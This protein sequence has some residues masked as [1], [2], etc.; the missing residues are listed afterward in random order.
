MRQIIIN[1][2]K[3]NTTEKVEKQFENDS[4]GY[5]RITVDRPRRETFQ[6]TDDGKDKLR[7]Q[8]TFKN[9]SE[10]KAKKEIS[11]E[12]VLE[13]INSLPTITYKNYDDFKKV[14]KEA[15]GNKGLKPKSSIYMSIKNSFSERDEN[16]DPEKDQD[17]NF[18]P[19]AEL[20]EYENIPLNQNIDDY[21]ETDVRPYAFDAWI[22]D[23]SRDNIGFEIPFTKYF[24]EYKPLPSLE[25]IDAEIR[26][27]QDDIVRGL[28]DLIK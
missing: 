17:G 4:F 12:E 7:Q 9:L 21:F 27:L 16:A 22:D 13:I 5:T 10:V 19:D 28:D 23:D 1:K 14:V 3:S 8:K 18:V 25:K 20:R 26:K 24:Y 15:F 2:D 6:I 11:Q